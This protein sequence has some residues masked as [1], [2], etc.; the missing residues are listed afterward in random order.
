MAT[1]EGKYYRVDYCRRAI[2]DLHGCLT[3]VDDCSSEDA[4]K[5]YLAAKEVGPVVGEMHLQ[6]HFGSG[7][8]YTTK[9]IILGLSRTSIKEESAEE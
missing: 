1:K 3:I 9:N 5:A 2:I 7:G 6:I 4:K 8:K